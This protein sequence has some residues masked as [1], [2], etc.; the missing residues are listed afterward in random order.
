MKPLQHKVSDAFSPSKNVYDGPVC[1]DSAIVV[2]VSTG[3]CW[4]PGKET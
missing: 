4:I 1:I 2:F 3:R